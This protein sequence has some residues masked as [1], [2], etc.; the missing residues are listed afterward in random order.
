MKIEDILDSLAIPSNARIDKRIPKKV[1]LDNVSFSTADKKLIQES[2]DEMQW[3][4][5][6]KATNIGV[7][8]YR[9]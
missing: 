6:L 3:V 5:A 1:L 4:A 9:D 8:Q 2:I 7:Q